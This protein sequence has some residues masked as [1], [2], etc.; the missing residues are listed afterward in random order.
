[1]KQLKLNDRK[2]IKS[3]EYLGLLIYLW[4]TD[5]NSP[6]QIAKHY[7]YH[8]TYLPNILSS[9]YRLGYL[10]KSNRW[11]DRCKY[12]IYNI[13]EKGKA[14]VMSKGYYVNHKVEMK[15]VMNELR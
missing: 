5:G 13:T 7:G 6:T 8:P 4:E 14:L 12:V 2:I 9:M 10:S 3:P 15:M 11:E 1:M